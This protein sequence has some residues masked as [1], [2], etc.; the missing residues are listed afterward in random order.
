MLAALAAAIIASASPAAV[1]C[2]SPEQFSEQIEAG[3]IV[4]AAY[5]TGAA[6]TDTMLV[7][8]T[9]NAIVI[10]GFKDG[11]MV[12]AH[13]VEGLAPPPTPAAARG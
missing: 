6:M 7:V 13:V 11:C 4:G 9:S 5:Y 2:V 3:T 10:Y 8:K 1:T 12:G